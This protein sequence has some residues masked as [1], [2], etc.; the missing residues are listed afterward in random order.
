MTQLT[1]GQRIASRRKLMGMSQETLAEKLAVSRQAVSKW[2]SDTTI[3]ELDKLIALGKLFEVS[4]GWLL[5]V[6]NEPNAQI[7]FNDEQ[8]KMVEKMIAKYHPPKKFSWW[9]A[10]IATLIAAAITF[11]VVSFYQEIQV[12]TTNNENAFQKISK[13]TEDNKSLQDQL[14]DMGDLLQQQN[15]DKKLLYAAIL[16]TANVDEKQEN[17]ALKHIFKPKVYQQNNK[18]FLHIQN[19]NIGYYE[20]IECV[21][22]EYA[23][24]YNV[25]YTIPAA[26]GY[27]MSFILVNEYGYE[28]E[29]LNLWDPGI[30]KLGT[31]CGFYMDPDNSQYYKMLRKEPTFI[32]LQNSAYHEGYEYSF[33]VPIY[34]PHIFAI[35]AVVYKD[36]RISMLH[37]G[38]TIW[39]QSFKDE[40]YE[41]AGGTRLN[42]GNTPVMP[43][44]KLNLPKLNIGDELK[45][46]LTAET[47]NGNFPQTQNYYTPLDYLKVVE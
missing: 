11:G 40:F 33:D 32:H 1:L 9:K 6:E 21:W 10:I 24:E 43:Q 30:E 36:I 8:L 4:V 19:P 41:A 26:D 39:E 13:L 46:I 45:L 12:L 5:G 35:T 18:A 3:P 31:Y 20:T 2:E 37:N 29:N 22:N 28:E 44:I 14:T 25:K 27:K 16:V 7:G 38:K 23:K 15:E 47:G 34:S 17:I 42:A